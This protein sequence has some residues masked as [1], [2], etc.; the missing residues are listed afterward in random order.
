[1]EL[2]S[3]VAKDVAAIY[4]M[5]ISSEIT[6]TSHNKRLSV[7]GKMNVLAKEWLTLGETTSGWRNADQEAMNV[8]YVIVRV[9]VLQTDVVLVNVIGAD[10]EDLA[11]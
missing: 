7:D 2:N 1:M 9:L 8:I 10:A 4:L 3:E 6:E 5:S 11:F